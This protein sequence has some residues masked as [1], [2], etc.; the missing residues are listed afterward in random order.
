MKAGNTVEWTDLKKK[1]EKPKKKGSKKKK[2]NFSLIKFI[3]KI[4]GIL[5]LLGALF[6][7]LVFIGALG[8]VPSKQQLQVIKNPIAS[9]SFII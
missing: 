9:G 6:F 7:I 1:P 3:A 8:P 2:S 5:F 4:A